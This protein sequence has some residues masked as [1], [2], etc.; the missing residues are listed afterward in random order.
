MVAG[1]GIEQRSLAYEAS[2]ITTLPS[3]FS[4]V[5]VCVKVLKI[6][7]FWDW[8]ADILFSYE[9]SLMVNYPMSWV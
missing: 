8:L 9:K 4:G 5:F 2:E 6:V 7:L 3:C 1:V